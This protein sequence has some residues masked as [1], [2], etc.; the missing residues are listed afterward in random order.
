METG[1]HYCEDVVENCDHCQRVLFTTVGKM[2]HRSVESFYPKAGT[3]H[4]LAENFAGFFS[5]KMTDIKVELMGRNVVNMTPIDRDS[6]QSF[7]STIKFDKVSL[8][9]ET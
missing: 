1:N 2:L 4:E 9:I 5:N 7:S 6:T 8:V 3:P